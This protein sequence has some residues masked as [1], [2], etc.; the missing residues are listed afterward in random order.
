[1]KRE[2]LRR[3]HALPTNVILPIFPWSAFQRIRFFTGSEI[4]FR[5][6]N[7]GAGGAGKEFC[8]SLGGNTQKEQF[9][10][11]MLT[12]EREQVR[13]LIFTPV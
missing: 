4:G 8:E 12:Y 13:A 5:V 1:M 7:G 10:I 3:I 11:V 2:D 9:T 6:I